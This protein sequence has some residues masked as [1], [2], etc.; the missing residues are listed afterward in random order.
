M[1]SEGGDKEGLIK[2]AGVKRW[3][4][5]KQLSEPKTQS[6]DVEVKATQ[7]LIK[8]QEALLR[9]AGIVLNEPA[10]PY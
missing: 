5:K 10:A 3:K 9:Q 1:I 7:F 2:G 4:L 8:T 6:S